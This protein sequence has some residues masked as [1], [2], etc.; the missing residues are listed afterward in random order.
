LP[1]AEIGSPAIALAK[2][3]S[4][5]LPFSLASPIQFDTILGMGKKRRILLAALL[6]ILLGG[7]AWWLLRPSE[8]SY[9][10]KSLSAWLEDY[11]QRLNYMER[12]AVDEAV[13]Q[14]RT[15]VSHIGTNA[16]LT[17][18]KMLRAHDSP[19][20]KKF[21]GFFGRQHFVRI[22]FTTDE[23]KNVQAAFAF[24]ALGP[25][26]SNAVPEL[27]GIY[28]ESISPQSQW[29]TVASIGGIGP[30]AKSAIPTLLRALKA[31]NYVLRYYAVLALRGIHSEPE[32][33][34]PALME[35]LQDS[36][37]SVCGSATEA[38][39][40][41]GTNARAA[42]PIL[43]QKTNAPGWRTPYMRNSV[44]NNL[45]QIDPEAAAKAGV[46]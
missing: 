25:E 7:F 6:V 24:A 41:F 39:G 10:G 21:I 40:A 38:L 18:L 42:I 44:A 27:I 37:L 33:V 20:K 12:P 14:I 26:A 45:K 35:H 36:N 13:S 28:D 31:T 22:N 17:L 15:A 5:S 9:Q 11:N 16:I 46:K 43:I 34:V 3:G 29:C 19:L 8:P 23:E 30:A 32:T 4:P 1:N 2:A